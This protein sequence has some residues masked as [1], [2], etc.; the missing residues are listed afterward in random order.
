QLFN[1]LTPKGENIL[2]CFTS[3]C[4]DDVRQ[5]VHLGTFG[6]FKNEFMMV[7]VS[8]LS[9]KGPW[10]LDDKS[11]SATSDF[12]SPRT[13]WEVHESGKSNASLGD[14]SKRSITA[15]Q[16]V[17]EQVH[18]FRKDKGTV[19]FQSNAFL[20]YKYADFPCSYFLFYFNISSENKGLYRLCFHKR[21]GS[22]VQTS[23]QLLFSLD[24]EI[25][26]KN[27][28]SY[29]SAGEI[30]LPKLYISMA[31]LLFLSGTV[32]I[33]ILRKCSH[34][35]MAALPVKVSVLDGP[36]DYHYVSCQGFSIEGWAVVCYIAYLSAQVL[37]NVAYIIEEATTD[38]GLWKQ[39]LFLVDLLCCGV[40]LFPVVWPIRHFSEISATGGKTIILAKL[41]LFRHCYFMIVCYV[42]VTL[43]IPILIK[44]AVPFQWNW[45]YQDYEDDLKVEAVVATAGVMKSMET[46][47]KMVNGSAE[48]QHKWKNTAQGA[49]SPGQGGTFQE[50]IA[51][52]ILFRGKGAT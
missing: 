42:Y 24:I 22:D 32:W 44:F 1:L 11:S 31:F 46:V 13:P 39:I 35:L 4:L 17:M 28:E 52:L 43:V 30:P 10:S 18:R 23:D 36:F 51:V 20:R 48:L 41:K 34:W 47:K 12:F 14:N 37:A 19:S 26:E 33:H 9:M 45:L 3:C 27:P 21:V 25:K 7:S 5:K 49:D 2:F 15:S 29:L 6:C 38:H 16:N 40:I 8:N 50:N